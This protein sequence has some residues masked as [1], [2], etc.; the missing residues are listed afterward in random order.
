MSIDPSKATKQ[1]DY[2]EELKILKTFTISKFKKE[3]G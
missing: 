2:K 3:K 1:F